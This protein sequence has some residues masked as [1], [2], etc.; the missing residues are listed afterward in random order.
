MFAS[1]TTKFAG[2]EIFYAKLGF[3]IGEIVYSESVFKPCP[4]LRPVNGQSPM[5]YQFLY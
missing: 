2:I 3:R 4:V 5:I 1:Q